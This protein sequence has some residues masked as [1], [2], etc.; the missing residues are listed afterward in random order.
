M[1]SAGARQNCMEEDRL[2]EY[3]SSYAGQKHPSSMT[4]RYYNKGNN[5]G[6][7]RNCDKSWDDNWQ[8]PMAQGYDQPINILT[9]SVLLALSSARLFQLRH[10]LHRLQDYLSQRQHGPYSSSQCVFTTN[11]MQ[12][13]FGTCRYQLLLAVSCV[14]IGEQLQSVCTIM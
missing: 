7:W 10:Q 11:E 13:H 6:G 4:T 2:R 14:G 9:V 1:L 5:Y 3:G 8:Q 12:F